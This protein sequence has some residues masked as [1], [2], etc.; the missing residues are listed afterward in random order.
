MNRVNFAILIGIFLTGG[1]WTAAG[2]S[3][4]LA[5]REP[6]QGSEESVSI[7]RGTALHADLDTS[8]DSKKA[9]A[10]DPVTAHVTEA[11]KVNGQTVIPK[12]AKLVG[13]ITQATARAKGDPGSALAV[14]FDKIVPKKGQ[15]LPLKTVIQAM[16][17]ALRFTADGS[18]DTATINNGSAAA[19][20]SPMGPS[21]VPP[22]QV[23]ATTGGAANP[24]AGSNESSPGLDSA[25]R[26]TPDSR[27]VIGLE[28]LHLS[29]DQS[30]ATAGSLITTSEK[31][32]RLDSGI[33]M[34]L[35]C[36]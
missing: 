13:H 1:I 5:R 33:R 8:L 36:E 10:G 17:P 27:G 12:N 7:P 11:V 23:A 29:T 4:E 25:G 20:G 34:L 3:T 22:G 9:K 6:A 24:A 16:A 15:E 30:S 18:P 14:V 2:T 32:V 26:L 31:S 35:V 28:G 21:H 19:Q